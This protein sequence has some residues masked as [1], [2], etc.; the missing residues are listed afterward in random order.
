MSDV[1]VTAQNDWFLMLSFQRPQ[2][3]MELNIPLVNAIRKSLK[4][5]L[6]IWNVGNY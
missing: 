3:C 2:V 5:F 6:G 4:A 1:K